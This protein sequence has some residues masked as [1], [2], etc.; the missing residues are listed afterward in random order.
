MKILLSFLFV[1]N[2]LFANNII[3]KINVDEI[4][5]EKDAETE[6]I[7]F[8]NLENPFIEEFKSCILEENSETFNIYCIKDMKTYFGEI[9]GVLTPDNK[10]IP[11]SLF[12]NLK[13]LSLDLD[14]YTRR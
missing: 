9:K 13:D 2:L 6:D 7:K 5:L 12:V 1:T 4:H 3:G 10:L 11:Y 8:Y 14:S